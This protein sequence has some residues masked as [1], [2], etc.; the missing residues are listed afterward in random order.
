[1]AATPVA[2]DRSEAPPATAAAATPAAPP[3]TMSVEGSLFAKA[4]EA[5]GRVA[6]A[7]ASAT[8]ATAGIKLAAGAHGPKGKS[9][10]ATVAKSLAAAAKN[11]ADQAAAATTAPAQILATANA[12]P[13]GAN[14]PAKS[15]PADPALPA[16]T[17]AADAVDSTAGKPAADIPETA[18]MATE[19]DAA[20]DHGDDRPASSD[21]AASGAD[22]GTAPLPA[23]QASAPPQPSAIAAVVEV[24]A[25]PGT[26]AP[27]GA[28]ATADAS[29][30][31][32]T[33]A[34][35]KPRTELRLPSLG[36]RTAPPAGAPAA[37]PNTP[38]PVVAG[39]GAATGRHE[40]AEESPKATP[41]GAAAQS[42]ATTAAGAPT[43]SDASGPADA[44]QTIP[45]SA[46][47]A[48]PA[49]PA[50]AQATT[51]RPASNG[52]AASATVA[53]FGFSATAAAPSTATA[54][55]PAVSTASG[56]VPVT[57][58]AVAITAHAKAGSNQFDIRLDP[59][60]LGR[61]E[62]RLG[63]DRDGQVTSHV[64]VD[65]A[66][67]LQLLQNQQPQLERALEQAGLKTAD[68]GLQFT[69]RD[70]SFSGQQNTGNGGTQ[71]GAAR[72]IVADADTTPLQT[73]Q[74]YARPGRGSGVDIRV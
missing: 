58:L 49:N 51:A 41:N 7:D 66:D 46:A 59:P 69:L 1:V 61:I 38:A 14:S 18:V 60:E 11:K 73:A 63:V 54:A 21:V 65:R 25:S 53:S 27:P 19:T 40:A 15:A 31:G 72:L 2:T 10:L 29:I 17:T 32:S 67:T 9:N 28:K 12:I 62:V 33:T 16:A 24:S 56:T 35:S 13:N 23:G 43:P 44:D 74:A 71:T 8:S 30:D 68:N 70:Q 39:H 6:S 45:R 20:T 3:T 36:E 37:Q 52:A 57:G 34:A 42:Q 26:P 22:T 5:A 64:T 50:A 48:P 47:V 4:A 55:H